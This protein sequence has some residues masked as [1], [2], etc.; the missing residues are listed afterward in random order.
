MDLLGSAQDPWTWQGVLLAVAVILVILAALNTAAAQWA[1][2]RHPPKGAFIE[3]DGV[4]LH[5]SD[6][7]SG[8]PVVLIHGN[9]V[10][11]DDYNTSDVAERLLGTCRVVI[12]DRP[13]FGHS[14]RPRWRPWE[15]FE[16][17]ELLHKAL[18]QLGVQRPVVVGHS[19][20]TLVALALA[21]RH[22]SDT[23]GLVLLAGYYFPT[24]RLDAL[25]VAPGAIPVLGDILRYTVSPIFGWLT[26]PL[27]KRVMF[28]PAP[29][30]SRFQAEYSTAMAM[31][32]SQIRAMCMEGTWMVP[33]AMRL[34]GHY[35]ALAM[36]VTIMAGDG[37]KIVSHRLSERLAAAIPGSTLHIISGAGHMVHHVATDRVVAAILTTESAAD[38]IASQAPGSKAPMARGGANAVA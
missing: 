1:E 16:Q 28:A 34:Q 7:G 4:R 22:P 11:G 36:P 26:M 30:T 31:R 19:W 14:D 25:M 3:V 5:Y 10:T 37:D 33:D 9:A 15:A 38:P 35:G 20:G 8:R 18:V 27:T 17:A 21:I 24:L 6:R 32:P 29:V 23:A 13:G 12:F 2:R